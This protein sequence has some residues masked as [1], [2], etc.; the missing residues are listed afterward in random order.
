MADICL[1]VYMLFILCFTRSCMN[2]TRSFQNIVVIVKYV[3]K[4]KTLDK[5]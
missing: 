2:F 1:I 4:T 5:L 3:E